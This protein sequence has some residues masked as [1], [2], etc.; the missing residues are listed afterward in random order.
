VTVAHATVWLAGEALDAASGNQVTVVA[1][2]DGSGWQQVAAPQ[3]GTGDE[4]L[5]GIA[6]A[7]GRTWAVGYFKTN[8]GRSPLVM[9]HK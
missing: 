4:V 2:N 3:P 1:R 5:S 8:I 7:G 9:L 6:S